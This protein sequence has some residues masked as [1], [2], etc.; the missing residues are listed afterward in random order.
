M[1]RALAVL[2]VAER[3]HRQRQQRRPLFGEHGGDLPLGG[4]V[5]ARVGPA[6]FPVVQVGLGFLQA[7]EAQPFQRRLLRM[8]DASS[9]PFPLRSG[10]RDAAGQSD[11][12]V[13]LQHVAVQGIERGIVDVGGEHALAKIVEHDHARDA[14]EPAKG[15]LMQLG[16]G[17]R[18]GAEHQQPN[19]LAAVAERQHEQPRAPVLAGVRI[20]HH[21]AGAVIDLSLFAGRGLDHR[22][23]F[24]RRGCRAACGR[25]AGRSDS[26]R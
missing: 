3:L 12:A 10:S 25:S 26:R 8:A 21:R 15:L 2:V 24:W 20:A 16:P 19:R 22:A 11:G 17:L 5:D 23:S 13:V 7:F 6:R 14:A 9:P 1:H 18:T 4:A